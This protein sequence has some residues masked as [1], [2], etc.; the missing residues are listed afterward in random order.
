MADQSKSI[1]FQVGEPIPLLWLLTEV[2]VKGL[3]TGAGITQDNFIIEKPIPAWVTTHEK[4]NP[5]ALCMTYGQPN[6]SEP[7]LCTW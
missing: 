5:G 3:L 4:Y 2:Q 7:S 6:R 1:I